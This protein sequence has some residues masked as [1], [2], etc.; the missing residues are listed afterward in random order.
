MATARQAV[1]E[2][3]SRL[4]WGGQSLQLPTQPSSTTL[5]GL[6]PELSVLLSTVLITCS[7]VLVGTDHV[8]DVIIDLST[9]HLGLDLL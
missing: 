7:N 8:D 6:A 3:I 9:I 4:H 5:L 2:P 1:Y